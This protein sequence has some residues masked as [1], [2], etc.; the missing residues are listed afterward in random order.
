MFMQQDADA[1]A[2][3]D[4]YSSLPE[5]ATSDSG[6]SKSQIRGDICGIHALAD[7]CLCL[8]TANK[9]Y[10]S[11]KVSFGEPAHCWWAPCSG[12]D[13]VSGTWIDPTTDT[14]ACAKN[15]CQV[16]NQVSGDAIAKISENLGCGPHDSD[17][18]SGGGGITLPPDPATTPTIG[19]TG[20][21]NTKTIVIVVVVVVL[22]LLICA[23]LALISK[24]PKT[25]NHGY[26][27][28]KDGY[29]DDDFDD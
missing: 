15:V 14:S 27:D 28:F 10:S 9:A 22:I 11:L 2:C 8:N 24:K 6:D 7:E 18:P 20:K 3:R 29:G 13:Q 19:P 17:D 5:N 1:N 26:V 21:S 25:H 12:K 23:V 16:V 4:W